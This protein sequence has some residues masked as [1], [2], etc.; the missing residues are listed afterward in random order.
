MSIHI[1]QNDIDYTDLGLDNHTLSLNSSK[2]SNIITLSTGLEKA[3]IKYADKYSVGA[4]ATNGKDM[5]EFI[6]TDDANGNSSFKIASFSSETVNIYNKLNITHELDVPYINASNITINLTDTSHALQVFDKNQKPLFQIENT[7]SRVSNLL[8]VNRIAPYDDENGTVTIEKF[9]IGSTLS[10]TVKSILSIEVDNNE[11]EQHIDQTSLKIQKYEG[12]ADI[13]SISTVSA[14]GNTISDIFTIDKDGMVGIGTALPDAAIT[15]SETFD[16]II[17]Y[18][19]PKYGD[20]FHLTNIGHLGIGTLDPTGRLHVKRTDDH[21]SMNYRSHAVV[22]IDME[23]DSNKN[24]SNVIL[25]DKTIELSSGSTCNLYLLD[26]N[27]SNSKYILLPDA[28][29]YDLLNGDITNMTNYNYISSEKTITKSRTIDDSS[30]QYSSKLS[31]GILSSDSGIS[32]ISYDDSNIDFEGNNTIELLY[33][34]D[35][36]NQE[37]SVQQDDYTTFSYKIDPFTLYDGTNKWINQLV[38]ELDSPSTLSLNIK[39]NIRKNIGDSSFKYDNLAFQ[40]KSTVQLPP[41]DLL[42]LSTENNFMAS[43]S[44]D[45]RLSLGNTAPTS[46]NYLIYSPGNSYM[47]N[48]ITNYITTE[49]DHISF[50]H[51][52]ISNIS[53]M[54]CK[55][56][57]TSNIY[58]EFDIRSSNIYIDGD[59]FISIDG[60]H[61][62]LRSLFAPPASTV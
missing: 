27:D 4:S 16:N 52:N 23:Y 22:K 34:I 60:E 2:T 62:S 20:K 19:G 31:I 25:E 17:Q 59:I 24:I 32:L 55:E 35:D 5:D 45:G 38:G 44:A 1:I 26:S 28:L 54:Q 14:Q 6:I 11:N 42:Y 51:Q 13:V 49:S 48:L 9:N 61:K 46:C 36:S 18:N 56:I 41:P 15:I 10:Q 40:Y 50:D 8:R 58:T 30:V 47:D 39:I 53:I 43:I 12:D 33:Y 37:P 21:E 7:D 3:L 29:Y 57:N